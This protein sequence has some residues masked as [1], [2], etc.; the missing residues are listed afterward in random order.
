MRA[1]KRINRTPNMTN[2]LAATI[3]DEET[4]ATTLLEVC[5]SATERLHVLSVEGH[6]PDMTDTDLICLVCA[7]LEAAIARVEAKIGKGPT[8][9]AHEMRKTES[10]ELL[11]AQIKF[12]VT[13]DRLLAAAEEARRS[14]EELFRLLREGR[15]KPEAA[16]AS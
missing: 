15:E 2:P 8:K 9:G 16:H 14:R 1:A 13:T 10:A 12:M 4:H 3:I 11:T 5:K 6:H 7:D